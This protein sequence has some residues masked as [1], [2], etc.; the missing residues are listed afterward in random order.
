MLRG[1]EKA[2]SKIFFRSDEKMS[3]VE[4]VNKKPNDRVY[5]LNSGDSSVNV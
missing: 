4:A 2:A 1:I 5:A 3:M